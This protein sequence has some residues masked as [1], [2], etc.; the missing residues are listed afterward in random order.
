[1]LL[2][3]AVV[4]VRAAVSYPEG[5]TDEQI[6]VSI[7]KTDVLIRSAMPALTGKTV[8]QLINSLLYS[9]QNITKVFQSAYTS[10]EESKDTLTGLGIDVGTARLAESLAAY[11]TAAAA[12]SASPTWAGV[13]LSGVA[14]GVQSD[15]DFANLIAAMLEPFNDVL[16]MLLCQGEYKA[17]VLTLTGGNGY[18]SAVL[19]LL[20]MLEC[21]VIVPDA[22]FTAQ[23]AANKNAMIYNI[24]ASLL[25][26]IDKI[27]NA[28]ADTLTRL[29]PVLAEYLRGDGF[30]HTVTALAEPISVRIG[31]FGYL[32]SG[33]KM[34]SFYM[35][36]Q[37]PNKYSMDFSEN[38]PKLLEDASIRSNGQS[39]DLPWIDLDAFAECKGNQN[40]AYILMMRWLIDL[41]K[42][43]T[44]KI[45]AFSGADSDG[46][47]SEVLDGFIKKDTDELII[48]LI[49]LF[50]VTEGTLLE[51]EWK[52][53][54]YTPGAVDYTQNLTREHFQN[55]YEGIDALID[56]AVAD[57]SD[58]KS[59]G[60]ILKK[61]IYT[62]ELITSL[63]KGLYGAIPAESAQALAMLDIPAAPYQ[64]AEE[65]SGG[66]FVSARDT[67][68]RFTNWNAVGSV[69]WGFTDGNRKGF[70]SAL[71][72]VLRPFRPALEMLLANGAITLFDSLN[73]TGGNGY[74][75]AVIPLLEALG[76]DNAKI[77]TY[78]D[79]AAGKGTDAILTDII[80]PVLDLIDDIAE[81]P[82]YHVIRIL[83]NI[84]YF[85][86]SNGLAQCVSNLIEPIRRLSKEFGLDLSSLTGELDKIGNIDLYSEIE[87][88]V[89]Q[90]T[91]R[92]DLN[93]KLRT[94]D[95][96]KLASLGTLVKL[97]S[98]RTYLGNFAQI[99]TVQA[100]PPAIMI[101]VLR[102]IV[103][104]L[105]DP[106]NAGV[107]GEMMSGGSGGNPMFSQ[108]AGGIG[109]EFN[110]MTNDELIEWLYKLFFRERATLEVVTGEEYIPTVIY[111]EKRK[112]SDI[113]KPA[114]KITVTVV[115]VAVVLIIERKN[116]E[117]MVYRIK[118]RKERGDRDVGA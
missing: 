101:T 12:L 95:L 54:P 73:I 68:Y 10:L 8:R 58:E 14:W 72:G 29:V 20:Q 93:L 117:D 50:T 43:N 33:T 24:A 92:S 5:V 65:L 90:L 102:Y 37:D 103:E 30:A 13:D 9:D 59:I 79:Y 76:C 47:I 56:E 60:E 82:V 81:K 1:M 108:F 67:L 69:Y 45:P 75:I 25:S 38:L 62:N 17:S 77:K 96:Q 84:L 109:G 42:E 115:L 112:T 78:R 87:N 116:I 113:L 2:P 71:L 70:R 11:P 40:A 86:N 15:T 114:L 22:D 106:E 55:V 7:E 4:S 66:N 100:D 6:T 35:F 51:F 110:E 27:S 53:A 57:L 34:L 107:L 99:D 74:N 36:L 118:R 3:T 111:Q 28:P 46:A 26:L 52:S 49:R 19:P 63:V 105:K 89:A 41:L 21:P 94:P 83:P 23:A 18:A 85:I 88:A 104:L 80:D 16:Y 44:D 61:K 91:D 48:I 32:F 64:L 98:K 97:Q 39:F 31:P